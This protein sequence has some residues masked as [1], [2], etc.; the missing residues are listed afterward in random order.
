MTN[1]DGLAMNLHQTARVKGFWDDEVDIHFVLAKLAL[2]HSE[3]SE[4]LEAVRKEHGSDKILEEMADIIIR[5]LDLYA[6]MRAEG[7]ISGSLDE[8]VA[9]KAMTNMT[10][11]QKHGNLA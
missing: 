3:V 1:F 4:T 2:V 7:W 10:R 6:G 8:A 11:P 5:L 9:A